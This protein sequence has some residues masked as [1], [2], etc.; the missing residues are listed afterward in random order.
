[1]TLELLYMPGCPH[2]GAA[3]DLVRGVLRDEGL[4]A[5]FKET[6]IANYDDAKRHCFPGSPTFRV[7][8]R[9]IEVEDSQTLAVG[10]ACRTYSV[11]GKLA[12]VPPRAWL[13]RALR[14]VQISEEEC[15]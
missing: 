2:H 15:E 13:E 3:L 12:G 5:E 4:T 9:D 6:P 11:N 8:G 14:E 7:N 10:L 1:M